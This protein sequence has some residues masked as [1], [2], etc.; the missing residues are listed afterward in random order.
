M[1]YKE[2]IIPM[3]YKT[4]Q[5]KLFLD[6]LKNFLNENKRYVSFPESTTILNIKSLIIEIDKNGYKSYGCKADFNAGENSGINSKGV[7]YGDRYG[8]NEYSGSFDFWKEGFNIFLR[9]WKIK[10]IKALYQKSI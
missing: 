1:R 8:P 7:F 6:N 10:K 4:F 9:Q 5:Q 3:G 2:T